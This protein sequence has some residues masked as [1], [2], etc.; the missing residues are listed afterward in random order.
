MMMNTHIY[1]EVIERAELLAKLKDMRYNTSDFKNR[2]SIEES[3][4]LQERFINKHTHNSC[5]YILSIL[6]KMAELK[7]KI[8]KQK[9]P[10][11]RAVMEESLEIYKNNIKAKIYNNTSSKE[12]DFRGSQKITYDKDLLRRAKDISTMCEAHQAELKT[13]EG[14][15][16]ME[17]D[18]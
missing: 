18:N 14:K 12:C 16:E 2:Q 4:S 5:D 11:K 3:I 7:V 1:E 10:N 9:N 8:S 15:T 17:L 6:P 13:K